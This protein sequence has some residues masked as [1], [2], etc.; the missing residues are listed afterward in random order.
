[1]FVLVW[2]IVVVVVLLVVWKYVNLVLFVV[3]LVFI[4]WVGEELLLNGF[5]IIVCIWGVKVVV[6]VF[7]CLLEGLVV[8]IWMIW[9][10]CVFLLNFVVCIL[11]VFVL[12]WNWR[13]FGLLKVVFVCCF[14]RVVVVCFLEIV[15]IV[16]VIVFG[17][18]ICVGLVVLG[19]CNGEFF[20][21]FKDL[22][23]MFRVGELECGVVVMGLNKL[24]MWIRREK[25]WN[26][27]WG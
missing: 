27:L 3:F 5:W 14:I 13:V 23:S 6:V 11:V 8:W 17:F 24:V 15:D 25:W 22:L 26:W 12:Y 20:F 18:G 21:G 7:I 16:I 19:F 9:I 4:V 10:G 2:I 1:M